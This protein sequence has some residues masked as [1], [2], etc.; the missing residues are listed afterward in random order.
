MRL[1]HQ[2]GII[3]RTHR[4]HRA[5]AIIERSGDLCAYREVD[6][7]CDE[8]DAGGTGTTPHR[9]GNAA[10]RAAELL[11][12][13]A[14]GT[15]AQVNVM[16]TSSVPEVTALVAVHTFVPAPLTTRSF[17]AVLTWMLSTRVPDTWKRITYS[18]TAPIVAGKMA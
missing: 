8:D 7:G 14:L 6:V 9:L 5:L 2:Q 11:Q 18:S 12:N 10:R 17:A 15:S 1:L 4:D 16:P 3:F 13:E